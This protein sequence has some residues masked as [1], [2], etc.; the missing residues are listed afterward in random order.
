MSTFGYGTG[1][2]AGCGQSRMFRALPYKNWRDQAGWLEEW[3][4]SMGMELDVLYFRY[5]QATQRA[6]LLSPSYTPTEQPTATSATATAAPALAASQDTMLDVLAFIALAQYPLD[7]NLTIA[8]RQ[9]L[10]KVG[11]T[12]LR[13]KGTRRQILN[14]ASQMTEGVALGWTAPPYNFS[15]L[16]PDGAPSAGYGSWVQSS[17][18]L[19]ETARPWIFGAVRNT[20]NN[21]SMA[22]SWNGL[23]VG[24]SQFR[25]GYSAAG[26]TVYATGARINILAHEHFDSW[27]AGLPVGWT[28]IGS[29]TINQSTSAAA[30]NWEF[31]GSAAVLDLTGAVSGVV[32]GLSQ[33]ATSINNQIA[34]R[35]QIDY[36]STNSQ[37]VAS[38]VA[39]IT[40][41]NR[42]GNTY[43]YNPVTQ[44]WSTTAY[45]IALP[46]SSTR[47]RYAADIVMQATGSTTTYGTTSITIT[48][49]S[50]S[51]GTATTQHANTLYRVGLYEKFDVNIDTASFG[52]RTLWLPLIDG[53]GWS[54]AARTASTG[55]LLEMANAQ[56]TS[57][58]VISS[59]T[60]ASFPY[61]PALTA[62]GFRAHGS[63]T[64]LL[65]GSNDFV[66]DWFA[67]SA[68][69][70]A[71]TLSPVVGET[72][73][74]ARTFTS[75]AP[76]GLVEQNLSFD[77]S[78][79]SYVGGVWV[80][81]LSA[82]NNFTDVTIRLAQTAIFDNQFTVKQSDGWK[83]LPFAVTFPAGQVGLP[84]FYVKWGSASSNG[85]IAVADAYLYD[86]TGKTGVLY[87][88][89][90]RSAVGATG[91]L[92]ATTCAAVT[93]SQGANVLHPLTQ[94][95]LSSVVRGTMALEIVPTFDAASQPDGVIFDV[96]QNATH[97][98]A[99]LR[100][101]S[102][103]LVLRRW[104]TSGN[105]WAASLALTSNA[106]P[107][108]GQIT[109]LRDTAITVRCVYDAQSTMLSAGN[110]NASGAIPGSWAPSDASVVEVGVGNDFANNNQFEGAVTLLECVLQGASTT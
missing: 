50:T 56:R 23:G 35:L 89:V 63:W 60:G 88:P 26:E 40:D 84:V 74:N 98:R 11:W 27:S 51:D 75:T 47:V 32:S 76:G 53:A 14:L 96:A 7:T 67:V 109:W 45:S 73:P 46:P 68:T 69:Q 95:T 66:T 43:Y 22:P 41:A 20:L 103:S 102:G 37:N 24:F 80:K 3:I 94:R 18:A 57:Y 101:T 25:A 49:K 90:V 70:G 12:A 85:Q 39:Q 59:S 92:G 86:V 6:N 42:D 79:K 48:V 106:T 2:Q 16:V 100:V 87:P 110:G 52:E 54:T 5:I 83:L 81:K 10:I 9:A 108:T 17:A 1:G 62:H 61:H 99:V 97:N 21:A 77:A 58:R 82:D 4:D 28:R 65:K 33:A 29:G 78:S 72:S 44:T 105:Q 8:Q 107:A 71:N 30:I 93:A 31:T 34:H 15:I 104:D 13:R 36:S 91:G 19:A 38:L 55:T 64:N